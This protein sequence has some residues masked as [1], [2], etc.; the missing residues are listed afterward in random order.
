MYTN[1]SVRPTYMYVP[2]LVSA[3][4]IYSSISPRSYLYTNDAFQNV[5][6]T[7]PN[8]ITS[9]SKNNKKNTNQSVHHQQV[10]RP[11]V[12]S[13]PIAS[14][15]RRSTIFTTSAYVIVISS[16]PRF[17]H[18]TQFEKHTQKQKNNYRQYIY[19]FH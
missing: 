3:F 16:I 8:M 19:T 9:T 1:K 4:S 12:T 7:A 13:P 6:P 2:P 5:Y 18:A 14:R 17:Q 11:N 15:R 10:S